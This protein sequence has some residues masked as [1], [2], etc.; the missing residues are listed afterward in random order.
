L[1]KCVYWLAYPEGQGEKP[2]AVQGYYMKL[3]LSSL[4]KY[5]LFLLCF[6]FSFVAES[7][8]QRNDLTRG[9]SKKEKTEN[10]KLTYEGAI[11][12]T[13]RPTKKSR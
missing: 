1:Q 2:E 9:N 11:G 7:P 13:A 4:M 5:V 10:G 8:A 12:Y 6:T 3:P